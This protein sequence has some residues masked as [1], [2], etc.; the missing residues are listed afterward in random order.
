MDMFKKGDELIISKEFQEIVKFATDDAIVP[1]EGA[2]TIHSVITC[3][4]GQTLF[5]IE[6]D[7]SIDIPARKSKFP[8]T[9]AQVQKMAKLQKKADKAAGIVKP[10]AAPKKVEPVKAEPED[11]YDPFADASADF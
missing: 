10:T 8:A 2:A 5:W 11:G 3:E 6:F 4:S 9:V 1:V 7:S